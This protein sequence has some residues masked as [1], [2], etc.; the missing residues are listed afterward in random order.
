[1]AE[2]EQCLVLTQILRGV[3]SAM[4]TGSVDGPL[5]PIVFCHGTLLLPSARSYRIRCRTFVLALMPVVWS[6]V[7]PGY[8]TVG[9]CFLGTHHYRYSPFL[10]SPRTT[11]WSDNCRTK[12]PWAHWH[13]CSVVL[14]ILGRGDLLV[15]HQ[16]AL[17]V[18]LSLSQHGKSPLQRVRCDS[19][20]TAKCNRRLISR[21]HWT[22]MEQILVMKGTRAL[23]LGLLLFLGGGV[24]QGRGTRPVGMAR[25][26]KGRDRAERTGGGHDT[27]TRRI[28]VSCNQARS[29]TVRPAARAHNS[30]V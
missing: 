12:R 26:S 4:G 7:L 19:L 6:K 25:G 16:E 3:L 15:G 5:V 28:S 21:R 1:M 14:S 27:A 11:V 29:S 10:P 30:G 17:C 20:H 22:A 13:S 9:L 24:A 8:T 18:L 2:Y 23:S